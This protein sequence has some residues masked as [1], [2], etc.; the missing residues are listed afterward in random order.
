MLDRGG[1]IL[2][3]VLGAQDERVWSG[4]SRLRE[5]C[6]GGVFFK[7]LNKGW[8]MNIFSIVM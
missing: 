5:G 3:L 2:E 7:L 1:V 6:I 8:S 4:F